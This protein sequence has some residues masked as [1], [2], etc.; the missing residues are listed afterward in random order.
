ME[1]SRHE[2]KYLTVERVADELGVTVKTVYNKVHLG[3]LPKPFKPGKRL[4]FDRED[5]YRYVANGKG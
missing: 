5:I 2:P 4:L 3:E 1:A